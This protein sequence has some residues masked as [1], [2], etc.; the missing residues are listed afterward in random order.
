MYC[1]PLTIFCAFNAKAVITAKSPRISDASVYLIY[2]LKYIIDKCHSKYIALHLS[3]YT[4]LPSF[5]D[6]ITVAY[7]NSGKI[8]YVLSH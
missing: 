7:S 1:Y 2:H 3:K 4:F 5:F 6:S 8:V